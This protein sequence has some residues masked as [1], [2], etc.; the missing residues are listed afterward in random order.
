MN[1]PIPS[2]KEMGKQSLSD[3]SPEDRL[4]IEKFK[5][6]SKEQLTWLKDY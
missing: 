6:E 5:Q 4:F 3:L 1:D 2:P